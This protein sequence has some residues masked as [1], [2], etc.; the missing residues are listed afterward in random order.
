[1]NGRRIRI[2]G[3]QAP[4]V[5]A[6]AVAAGVGV[7]AAGCSPTG[8]RG[9]DELLVFLAGGAV[10]WAAASAPWW[11]G[12]LVTAIGASLAAGWWTLAL[13]VAAAVG[14]LAIGI[15][16]RALPWSRALVAAAALQVLARLG[17]V[18][19]FGFTSLIAIACTV[20]VA[21]LGIVR[22]PRAERRVMWIVVTGVGGF[23][24]LASAG[25]GFGALHARSD[26][27]SGNR[28]AKEGLDLI[29]EGRFAEAQ[30]SLDRARFYFE[31]ADSALGR[32]WTQLGR[33]VPVVAQ[34]RA[35]AG[36]LVDEASR[37]TDVAA[38][39]LS[40]ID[41]DSLRLSAGR[42]DL[43]AVGRLEA[44]LEE[45][46]SAVRALSQAIADNQSPWLVQ[47]LRD[48][49]SELQDDIDRQ[50]E[51]GDDALAAVRR[52]PAMLGADGARVY[53]IAFTT[54]AEA[55]GLGGFM[56]NWA[57]VTVDQGAISLT[58]F[59]RTTDLNRGGNVGNKTLSGPDD[60]LANYGEFLLD[61]S[62]TRIVGPEAW[63]N[64]TAS[65]DFPA[66]AQVIAELYPQSGG[67]QLDGVFAMD[68]E[69][70]SRLIEITGP[71]NVP[72]IGRQLDAQSVIPY[73]M[74]EQY[75]LP[76]D[77]ARVDALETVARETVTR[78][79]TTTLPA[80][81]DLADLLSP[82]ARQGRLVGWA[83]RPEEED[84]LQRINM[85]GALPELESDGLAI[86]F[87]NAN[88]SKI[89]DLLDARADYSVQPD[90]TTGEATATL[91]LTL[92]NNAPASG[93][94]DV[95]IGNLVDLP[96]GTNS[97]YLSV[98]TPLD[99]TNATVD[100]ESYPFS[101]NE[102]NGYLVLSAFVDIP[103]KSTMVVELSLVGGLDLSDGYSLVLRTPPTARP[104]RTTVTVD[105]TRL[106]ETDVTPGV[107]RYRPAL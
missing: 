42:I 5:L 31:R 78:L 29:G 99:F 23:V 28:S 84:V 22:R 73:L 7:A 60:L 51:R 97:T 94:P 17:S 4:L 93:L 26:L 96:K 88:G 89:D 83:A 92:T 81:P 14:G 8:Q 37:L 85:S 69:T 19:F 46:N 86:T 100:G 40:Q 66:V 38:R 39:A 18:G 80:P 64:I 101:V 52:A 95:I 68:I 2:W 103:P 16:R 49:L 33:V 76:I 50:Q 56:G 43:G 30:V 20:A 107:S 77:E 57:E 11:A 32:P 9:L 12:V 87:N 41:V 10:V 63:S 62:E 106:A 3:R 58:G 61:D 47:P 27:E 98:Y 91:T 90:E 105:G 34:H 44:P 48:R 72:E 6:V 21:V 102:D 36:D 59:G 35:A 53:F 13:G 65:P 71:V 55:R 54:P 75:L 25:F 24:L 45:L 1:M 79:L 74:R 104:F 67:Q 15:M 82:M 70:I